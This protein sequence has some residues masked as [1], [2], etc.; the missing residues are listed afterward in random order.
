MQN[1]M[2]NVETTIYTSLARR[3]GI[4]RLVWGK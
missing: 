4:L 1:S 3:G 2:V